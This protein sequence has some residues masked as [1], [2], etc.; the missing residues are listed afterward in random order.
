VNGHRIPAGDYRLSWVGDSAN[1]HVTFGNGGKV[2]AQVDAKLERR[3]ERSPE[4]ELIS[5]TMKDGGLALGEV[6]PGGE[7]GVLVFPVS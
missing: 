5:R 3:A 1:V 4:Q 6:R 7:K 2:V